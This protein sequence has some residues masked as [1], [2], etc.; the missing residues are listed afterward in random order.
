MKNLIVQCG[1]GF[2]KIIEL[3]PE[4]KGSNECK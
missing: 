3:Q 4:G 2:I 1:E